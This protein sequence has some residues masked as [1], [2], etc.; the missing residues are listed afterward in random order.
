MYIGTGES[1]YAF[2]T[3]AFTVRVETE[4]ASD[5]NSLRDNSRIVLQLFYVGFQY[6]PLVIMR[7]TEKT[8]LHLAQTPSIWI[9]LLRACPSIILAYVSVTHNTV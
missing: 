9:Y 6:L 4:N 7:S 2:L 3:H 5:I 1:Q 8:I